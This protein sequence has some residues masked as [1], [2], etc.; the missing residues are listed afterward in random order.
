[1]T[2]P[3]EPQPW[4]LIRRKIAFECPWLKVR[5]DHCLLPDNT[6]EIDYYI[7]ERKHVVATVALTPEYMVVL[8]RQYRHAVG[9]VMY[10]VPMGMLDTGEELEAGARRELEEESGFVPERMIHLASL[11]MSPGMQAE[12]LHV[13]L[14]VNAT[15]TGTKAQN[16]IEIIANELM[17]LVEVERAISSG[18]I[19]DLLA[20]ASL[21]LALAHVHSQSQ[22]QDHSSSS[23]RE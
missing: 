8:N 6:T 11:H 22:E 5:E 20:V 19:T 7:V 3:T 9:A 1:M 12:Q 14:G 23:A 18:R 10:D 15:L 2:I 17:P 4:K 13:F 16:P 21:Q